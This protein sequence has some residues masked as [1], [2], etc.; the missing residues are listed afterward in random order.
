VHC[1]GLQPISSDF[2][3]LD[4]QLPLHSLLSRV[5]D[6]RTGIHGLHF[7]L[8]PRSSSMERIHGRSAPFFTRRC[9]G[10]IFQVA[11]G[12]DKTYVSELYIYIWWPV[13]LCHHSLH[14]SLEPSSSRM[15]RIHE[16]SGP[17]FNPGF[18]GQISLVA[19]GIDIYIGEL[20]NPWVLQPRAWASSNSDTTDMKAESSFFS[21]QIHCRIRF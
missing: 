9:L 8:E 7:S 6:S 14:F 18:M 15:E 13:D 12:I 4:I 10:Q 19:A 5:R 1:V 17:F 11:A 21:S 20:Y 3:S 2:Y 16:S